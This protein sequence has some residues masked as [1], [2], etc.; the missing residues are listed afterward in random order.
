MELR[1]FQG[2]IRRLATLPKTRAPVVSCY[3]RVEGGDLK[4]RRVFAGRVEELRR[5]F[6]GEDARLLEE[7]LTPIERFLSTEVHRGSKGVAVFSRAGRQPFFLALQFYVPLPT[8]IA[9]DTLPNI[10]HLVELKDTYWRFVVLVCSQDTA[11]IVSVNLGAVTL[12][13]LTERPDLRQRLGR[14]WSKEQFQRHRTTRTRKFVA[15]TVKA[16]SGI[17]AAGNY[18]HL[19]LAGDSGMTARV[20]RALPPHMAARLVRVI[21]KSGRS[22]SWEIVAQSISAFLEAEQ[23]ESKATVDA[24]Q[25]Q[26]RT[27][28]LAVAGTR[29]SYWA[30]KLGQVETLVMSTEY[31]P[32]PGWMCRGCR[33]DRTTEQLSNKCPACGSRSLEH[34]RIREAMLRLAEQHRC[35]VELVRDSA[36]MTRLG[37]VGCLLR[38]SHGAAGRVPARAWTARDRSYSYPDAGVAGGQFGS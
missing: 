17:M 25:Q 14:G 35:Q 34:L 33:I 38:F 20:R 7:A 23:E 6:A 24:L 15:D 29:A 21:R 2:H 8:W 4:H 30:L 16:L 27:G 18:D 12:D 3:L 36:T 19:I 22:G 31:A 11:R 32:R 9:A 37:G 5:S 13:L 1:E 10:Y 28:S 26:L